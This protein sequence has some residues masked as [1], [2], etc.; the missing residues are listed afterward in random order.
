M[1]LAK[2]LSAV[3]L[4]SVSALTLAGCGQAGG[5]D[6]SEREAT[7]TLPEHALIQEGTLQVAISQS[8]P[9]VQKDDAGEWAGVDIDLMN[10]I[11]DALGVDV[12]F[13]DTKYDS[14]VPGLKAGRYDL[15]TNV[16]DFVERQA[17][18]DFVDYAQSELTIQ[19]V[20]SGDFQPKELLDLCDA[21]IGYETGTAGGTT[22]SETLPQRCADASKDF[23]GWQGFPDRTQLELA[24]R[25]GRIAGLAAPVAGNDLAVAQSDGEFTNLKIEDMNTIPGVVAIYG[26]IADKDSR[27]TE[28][29]LE[30]L[31]QLVE[32]GTYA[33]IFDRWDI[34]NSALEKDQVAIN[35]S[36]LTRS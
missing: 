18:T 11:G 12:S 10:E 29:V 1:K 16:G 34:P 28:P 14:L 27:L 4:V 17:E 22:L 24:L 25:S 30:A 35:G 19:V 15:A 3:A 13:I 6:E 20:S 21:V 31:Q 5:G 2:T 23:A 9:Y 36:T 26:M 7:V 33:E 8:P 32:D